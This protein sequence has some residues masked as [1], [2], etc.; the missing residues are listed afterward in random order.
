M[1]PTGN[2]SGRPT[3]RR[4][5]RAFTLVELLLVMTLLIIVISL[6]APTLKRF[7][8]GRSIQS[9]A[10]RLL[11]LTRN[12][13]TRAVSEGIPMLLW[14]DA[15]ER[16]YGLTAEPGYS[17]IDPRAVEFALDRDLELEIASSRRPATLVGTAANRR[18][19]T[20][21][22]SVT[23]VARNRPA[24]RFQADGSIAETSPESVRITGKNGETVVVTLSRL[25]SSYEIP[26]A[27]NARDNS[28]P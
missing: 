27:T 11:A 14:L 28:R 4:P 6:G 21:P 23:G 22:E 12:G 24:I 19:T 20:T 2:R 25:G 1:L 18:K 5:V 8:Q 15:K 13:Q 10:G 16:S 26:T 9:E 7:F 17:D 3:G